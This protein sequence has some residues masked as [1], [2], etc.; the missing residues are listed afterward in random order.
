MQMLV[1]DEKL[2]TQPGYDAATFSK[3]RPITEGV[4]RLK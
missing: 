1:T 2:L 3:F 4:I